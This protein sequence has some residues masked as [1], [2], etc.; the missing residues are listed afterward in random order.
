MIIVR[1]FKVE[2]PYGELDFVLPGHGHCVKVSGPGPV[3]ITEITLIDWNRQDSAAEL[4]LLNNH[5]E[6]RE[7]SVTLRNIALRK[8]WWPTL[9]LF[10]EPEVD[11][12]IQV[13]NAKHALTLQVHY[14]KVIP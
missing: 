4:V 11:V 7:L 12:A 10:T 3:L 2:T 1:E 13:L 9:V 6:S 8:L 5:T 14:E